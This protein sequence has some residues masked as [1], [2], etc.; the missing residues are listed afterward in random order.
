MKIKIFFATL[1]VL[2]IVLLWDV[3]SN[4]IYSNGGGSP[5]GYAHAPA[6]N[7]ATC[8]ASGCHTGSSVIDV[9]GIITSNIP[10][11]GYTP[12][13]TYTI[14]ATCMQT[15]IVRWGFE[16]TPQSVTGTYLGQL[17][18][19]NIFA[20]KI[21]GTKYITHKSTGNYGVNMKTWSFNW[22]APSLGTGIVSFYGS[23][24]YANNNQSKSGD[25]IHTSSLIVNENV[26][27]S[28]N[29][30]LEQETGF[31]VFPNPVTTSTQASLYMKNPGTVR[32]T[33]LNATG[34]LVQELCNEK[35][36]SGSY[37]FNMGNLKN[38]SSGIY[39]IR[40]DTESGSAVKR[41][42]IL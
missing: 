30:S 8:A 21:V 12:G 19:T 4:Y 36:V 25:V 16:I 27:T 15:G 28:I 7:N 35:N 2:S 18:V 23:F 22:I 17:V 37:I 29:N 9:P 33:L 38:L 41:A 13:Q 40:L 5:S 14:T 34:D 11:V 26:A 42:M 39:F 6:D 1:L 24:N 20:T 10:A 32:L 31:S 3:S